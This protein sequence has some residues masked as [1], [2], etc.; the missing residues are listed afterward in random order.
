MI[1]EVNE[2]GQE[3][4]KINHVEVFFFHLL[5]HT[6]PLLKFYAALLQPTCR[7]MIVM[8]F[9]DSP[10]YIPFFQEQLQKSLDFQKE[11]LQKTSL[12]QGVRDRSHR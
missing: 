4:D 8:T 5:F 1:K 6:L 11:G 9:T 10:T 3:R 7:K 12:P 2:Q